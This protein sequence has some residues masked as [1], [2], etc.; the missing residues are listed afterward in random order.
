MTYL[1]YVTKLRMVGPQSYDIWYGER[2]V[3]NVTP[4][5]HLTVE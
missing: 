1:L 4:N 5:Q 2:G 3:W